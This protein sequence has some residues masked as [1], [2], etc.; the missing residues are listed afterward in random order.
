ME[1][2]V[3]WSITWVRQ[4]FDGMKILLRDALPA[5]KKEYADIIVSRRADDLADPWRE[6]RCPGRL[7]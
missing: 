4:I 2:R 5:Y 3:A 7:H 6:R 1:W